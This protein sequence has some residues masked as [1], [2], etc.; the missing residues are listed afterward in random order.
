MTHWRVC[1]WCPPDDNEWPA[2]AFT[3]AGSGFKDGQTPC[4]ACFLARYPA[5]YTL[6]SGCGVKMKT[7]GRCVPR[8]RKCRASKTGAAPTPVCEQ[9]GRTCE[10]LR[11]VGEVCHGCY[12]QRW[13]EEHGVNGRE[14][15][16]AW[17][18]ERAA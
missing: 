11:V 17:K 5:R 13:R 15:I 6:C 7:R 4:D 14:T 3:A 2:S 10:G 9:C 18:Q 8:C 16:G 1:P 12:T